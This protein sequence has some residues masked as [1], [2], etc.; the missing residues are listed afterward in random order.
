[1]SPCRLFLPLTANSA[2]SIAQH[3]DNYHDKVGQ[4]N[5]KYSNIIP[6][7]SPFHQFR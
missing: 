3:F 7:A 1:M 6:D 2:H 4:N 5:N